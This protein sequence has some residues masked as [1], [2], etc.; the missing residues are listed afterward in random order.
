MTLGIKMRVVNFCKKGLFKD[1]TWDIGV[2]VNK[3]ETYLHSNV[4][5]DK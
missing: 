4:T 1:Y 3:K 2:N 5:F